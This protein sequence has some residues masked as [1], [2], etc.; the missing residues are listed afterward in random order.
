MDNLIA[1][2]LQMAISLGFHMV[3]AALGIGLPLL[4]LVAEGLWLRT[5]KQVYMDLARKWAKATGLLFAIGAVSGTALSF[6]LGLLWPPFMQFA[7]PLIGPAFA[8]EGYAFFIEAIF[9]GLYLYG[10]NRLKP[11]AHWLCGV[12]VA[13]S[14]AASGVLVMSA[15]SWMQDPVGFTLVNG[16]PTNIDPLK[17]LTNPSWGVLALHLIIAS[18]MATA[19]MVAATYAWGLLRGRRDAYHKSALAIAMVLGVITAVAQPISGDASARL[20]AQT[21]PVKLAAMESQFKTEAGAPLR[22][23]G[24]P[25]LSSETVPFAI[26]IPYGLSFLATHDINATI[27]GLDTVPRDD[28]PAVPVVHIAFQLMVGSGLSILFFALVYW[29]LRW[30]KREP[31]RWSLRALVLSGVLGVVALEAGWIVT[32]VGRQPWIIYNVMRTAQAVTPAPGIWLTFSAFVALYVVLAVTLV[33]LLLRLATGAPAMP[34]EQG[35]LSQD[36]KEADRA[37]V[38]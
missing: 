37:A 33:W 21:Q 24:I 34:E 35:E 2:R 8:L 32:E 12:P 25:D 9:L 4:M 20:V 29:Y 5:R 22:I 13:L 3:F 6:E 17:A 14:G 11:V 1:A 19:F 31:G 38:A 16:Q 28:W 18:Y 26:E 10:W 30:R 15:N 27:Q 23:G 36:R 7:G